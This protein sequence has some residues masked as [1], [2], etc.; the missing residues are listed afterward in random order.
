MSILF[1]ISTTPQYVI[2]HISAFSRHV[3]L[4]DLCNNV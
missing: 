2:Q 1:H 4:Q 3:T